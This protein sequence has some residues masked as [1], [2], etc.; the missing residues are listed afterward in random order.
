[1]AMNDDGCL[2]EK[3]YC[4]AEYKTVQKQPHVRECELGK[5]RRFWRNLFFRGSITNSYTKGNNEVLRREVI[6]L[7]SYTHTHLNRKIEHR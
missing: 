6:T 2:L 1:M 4:S 5:N 7:L 3:A